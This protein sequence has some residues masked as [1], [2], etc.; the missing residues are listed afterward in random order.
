MY[1]RVPTSWRLLLPL[2]DTFLQERNTGQLYLRLCLASRPG[3]GARD[4]LATA[5]L[6]ASDRRLAVSWP[7]REVIRE[8]I[9]VLD[10]A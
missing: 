10:H 4:G 9:I 7:A 1:Q 6:P 2:S 5:R 3:P 8:R